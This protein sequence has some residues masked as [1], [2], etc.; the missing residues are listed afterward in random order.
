MLFTA[1]KTKTS[2]DYR[3]INW[4]FGKDYSIS[5]YY[6]SELFTE[7]FCHIKIYEPFKMLESIAIPEA[8]P[9]TVLYDRT[10]SNTV[11]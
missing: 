1:N 7:F 8:E 11:I 2:F 4:T 10:L 6:E 5:T 9:L 3:S